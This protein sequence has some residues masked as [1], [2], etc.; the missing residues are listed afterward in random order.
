MI[1]PDEYDKASLRDIILANRNTGHQ[2]LQF[3]DASNAA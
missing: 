1:I 2:P 3:I